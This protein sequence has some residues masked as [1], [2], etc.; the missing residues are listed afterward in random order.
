MA[1]F[2]SSK[3]NFFIIFVIFFITFFSSC[4]S[5]FSKSANEQTPP[6]QLAQ[7]SRI[8]LL[9]GSDDTF[10]S[11]NVAQNENK[12]E[13]LKIAVRMTYLNPLDSSIFH[14]R[15]YFFLE[16]FNDDEDVLLPDS[17]QVSMFG[18]KPLWLRKVDKNELDSM[19][20]LENTLSE[21]YLIA[22]RPAGP[23][24]Q[25]HIK[26]VLNIATFEPATFDFSFAILKT[27][28]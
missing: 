22:F 1:K 25:K 26:V 2:A 6:Q 8:V 27:Y 11:Q 7:N 24:E 3:A 10:K 16:I 17:M 20:K 13:K 12:G 18:R 9:S 19:L 15:E 28:L 21:G 23:F 14:N 4:S 5:Y